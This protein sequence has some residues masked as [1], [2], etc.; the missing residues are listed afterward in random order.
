MKLDKIKQIVKDKYHNLASGEASCNCSCQS[1]KISESIGYTKDELANVGKANMGLGCGN[2]VAIS[3]ISEGETVVDLGSG[4]GI[5][6]ILAAQKVGPQGK[7]IGIDFTQAMIDI[8]LS[9]VKKTN[10][11][12]IKF[13]LADIENLPLEDESVDKIISNCVINLAP[14]KRAVFQEA[15]RVLKDTGKMYISDIVLLEE[16]SKEQKSNKEL[17]SSCVAGAL[18]KEDYINLIKESGFKVNI[19]NENKAISKE[20]SNGINLESMA[21]EIM[22]N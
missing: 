12:N 18:L 14:D 22:K 7:V 9:N 21:L 17:I 15:R 19:L 2:P 3:N 16:L 8:A 6:C 4:G 20:Q 11:I 5:D 1:K 13:K 10:H